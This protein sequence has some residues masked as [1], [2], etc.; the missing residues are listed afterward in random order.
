M[1]AVTISEYSTMLVLR[2]GQMLVAEEP[3]IRTQVLGNRRHQSGVG[4][5]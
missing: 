1:G 3:S 4:D 2:G 5:F